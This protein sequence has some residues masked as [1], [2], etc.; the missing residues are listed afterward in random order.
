MSFKLQFRHMTWQTM[1]KLQLAL[2]N[3]TFLGSRGVM[4][5]NGCSS[6]DKGKLARLE[7][8]CKVISISFSSKE[9]DCR[10]SVPYLL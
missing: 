1:L 8:M 5:E 3:G 10:R 2:E 9:T 4:D 6:D 7:R